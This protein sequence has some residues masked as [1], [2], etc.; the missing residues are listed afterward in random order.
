VGAVL[1]TVRRTTIVGFSHPAIY[2]TADYLIPTAK[3]STNFLAATQPFQNPVFEL[4]V[5]KVL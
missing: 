2:S 4:K 5:L 3:S 1:P